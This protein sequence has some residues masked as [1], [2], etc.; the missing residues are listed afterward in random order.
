MTDTR[1][2]MISGANRG[3]GAAI[4]SRLLEEGW[5]VS[6]GVRDPSQLDWATDS[7]RTHV[8]TYEA[9]AGTE[10]AWTESAIRE[11]GRIDAV[12]PNAGII[13]TKSV[14][15]AEDADLDA[16]LEIN[17][18]APR[19]L[20]QAAW[21]AL[22]ASGRGRIAII[23]SLSG[24]RV[25]SPRTGLYSISKYAVVALA[26]ALR[27]EGWQHGIRCT[28]ICPGLSETEMGRGLVPDRERE[29]THPD[30]IARLVSL[31][32]DLRN[33]SSLSEMYINCNDGELY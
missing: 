31:A 19:R 21:P 27:H 16:M 14:I 15:D 24:K 7:D 5:R 20:V 25:A 9:T 3:L 30:D 6:L 1:V 22:I 23:A 11:F 33:S 29:L 8:F 17:V 26:H 13:V 10:R 28:A 32:L 12:I 4:A 18:K 2:A